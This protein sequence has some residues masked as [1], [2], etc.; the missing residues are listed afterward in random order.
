[1]RSQGAA[2]LAVMR[3]VSDEHVP[4]GVSDGHVPYA[5]SSAMAMMQDASDGRAYAASMPTLDG[6]GEYHSLRGWCRPQIGVEHST[7]TRRLFYSTSRHC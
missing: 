2:A 1:M 5:D 3:G 4:Q 7:L 6:H